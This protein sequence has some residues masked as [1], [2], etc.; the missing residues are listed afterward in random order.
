MSDFDQS[1]DLSD[2]F[3]DGY[4]VSCHR[5]GGDGFILVC[6]D[7]MCQGAGEC[8]PGDVEVMCPSCQGDG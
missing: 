2:D 3:D 8:M 7:D 4:D 5:C 6:P 1:Y